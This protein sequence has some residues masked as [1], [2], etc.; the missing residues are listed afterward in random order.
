MEPMSEKGR[1]HLHGY[2]N[3]AMDTNELR[4]RK[5][6]YEID[7]RPESEK[8]PNNSKSPYD[9][10][11]EDDEDL[12]A[13]ARSIQGIQNGIGNLY[14][15]WK[16]EIWIGI[17]TILAILYFAYF[18]YAMFF[19]FGDEGSIRLLVGTILAVIGITASLIS[20][21]LG[22]KAKCS[23]NVS[24]SETGSKV[25]HWIGIGILVAIAVFAIIYIIVAIAI[26]S[27]RNLVSLLGLALFII[28]F[29]IFS[30]NPARVKW[31]PVIWGLAI[32]FIFALLI[33]RWDFGFEAFKWLGD[34][35]TEFL[36]YTDAGSKFVFGD[37]YEHHFFAFK[38]ESPLMIRPFLPEMT[39]SEIHA[40][41]TGGFATI[42][43]S[44][45][46]AY[47]LYGVPAN[48]LL[49]ASVM[50]AP[51]ALAMSKLFYPETKKTKAR[52]QD[53]YNMQKGPERNVIEAASIGA[54]Q[55]IKLV[56]N[57]AANLIAF[58][59]MLEFI[60]ATLT[61]FGSRVGLE[62]PEYESLTFQFICSYVFWPIAFF[63]GVEI[64]DC[65]KVAEMIGIKTFINEFVAYLELS[66]YINNQKNLTW[67]EGLANKTVDNITY[68]GTWY[69][70]KNDIVYKD[71]NITLVGGIMQD[72]S[73]VIATYAL[74]GF[75]N[76]GSI[77]IM[78]GALGAMAPN[79]KSDISQVVVRAMIAGNVACFMTA[80]I[81][82]KF[83]HYILLT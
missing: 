40:V 62:E 33:L 66:T 71:L 48:H 38:S 51:A 61:W 65:R 36:A 43:G 81:A 27:P 64:E 44:V 57:I 37:A 16:N 50:S 82:G 34:R 11:D 4:Q 52:D 15:E 10:D 46:A 54:S 2:D 83:H 77:G 63:M 7:S 18:G 76:I 73:V 3:P 49:S 8:V 23:C 69:Y 25:L 45:M 32:Q 70:N 13:C 24:E 56:A 12:S 28:L 26:P 35:V 31:R 1:E 41:C 72:R 42:A 29:Y 30:H 19:R 17:W 75:S 78:L 22:D 14:K 21:F 80:C 6:A 53:V 39:K 67:Y 74:C 60:N 68:T 58:I 5:A 79:R 20:S 59:A 9:S 47:I 55:S